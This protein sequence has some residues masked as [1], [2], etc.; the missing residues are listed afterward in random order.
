MK[1]TILLIGLLLVLGA[2]GAATGG[3]NVEGEKEDAAAEPKDE[4]VI[5]NGREIIASL[6][7]T[8]TD[9]KIRDEKLANIKKSDDFTGGYMGEPTDELA[10]D[11]AVQ[12][13]EGFAADQALT[14][15][16]GDYTE[17][18]KIGVIFYENQQSGGEQSGFWIGLKEP[19]ERLDEF[20]AILQ[21][22]VDAGE[23]LAEPIYIYKSDYSQEDLEK[24]AYDASKI[25]RPMQEA[26]S[27][28]DV[29]T[30]SVSGD[31]LTGALEIGHNFLTEE[32]QRQ[33]VEAF[34]DHEVIIEQEGRMVPLP[35]EPDVVYPNP[36]TVDEWSG[37]GEYIVDITDDSFMAIAVTPN[38][39]S[40]TGGEDKHFSAIGFSFKDAADKFEVGQRVKVEAAGGIMQSD[41]AQGTAVFV[42]VLPAYKPTGANLSEKEVVQQALESAGDLSQGVPAID[43]LEY[44]SAADLWRVTIIQWNQTFEVEIADK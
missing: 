4:K 17:L 27:N 26:H 36:E 12:Q 16:Y 14:Q 18:N 25:M 5:V 34:P 11:M 37:E 28:P 6:E 19:D 39:Y 44:D 32:Q 8:A 30:Y 21:E 3:T 10:E 15:V 1:K 43:V 42:E 41:P 2:C 7:Q 29:A 40:A 9:A 31:T 38:D 23:I 20:L 35:G 13:I 22:Q 24:L 33:I